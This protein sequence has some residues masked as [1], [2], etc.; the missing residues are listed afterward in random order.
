MLQRRQRG[1]V[2][3]IE[4]PLPAT[5]IVPK[6]PAYDSSCPTIV[7]IGAGAVGLSTAYQLA[8][9]NHDLH[10]RQN[11]TVVDACVTPFGVTLITTWEF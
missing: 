7:I 3:S 10:R 5:S 6:L 1:G 8:K 11:I 9:A 4:S 2:N